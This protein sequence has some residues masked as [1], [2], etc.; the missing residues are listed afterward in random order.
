MFSC[1]KELWIKEVEW[2]QILATKEKYLEAIIEMA[3]SNKYLSKCSIVVHVSYCLLDNNHR[4]GPYLENC[5]NINF[6]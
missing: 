6:H 5:H 4:C 1:F 3:F 2:K